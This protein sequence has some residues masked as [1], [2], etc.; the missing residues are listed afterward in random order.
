M[1]ENN[2]GGTVETP[3]IEELQK[4][5]D[6]AEAKIVDLKKNSKEDKSVDPVETPD[7]P[8]AE[9]SSNDFDKMYEERKFFESNPDMVE[10][11][12]ALNGYTSKWLSFDDAKALVEQKDET[13]LNR[14]KTQQANFTNWELPDTERLNY[15]Q[16]EL[17]SM[18]QVQY[19]KVME[20]YE[21][22]K[23]NIT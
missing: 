8:K 12:E 23:I 11:K 7:Q 16:D 4:R 17:A 21:S 1:S 22:W 3:S 14:K 6:K 15:T 18:S 10:F 19:N 9:F 5:L 20:W 2:A 13:Y